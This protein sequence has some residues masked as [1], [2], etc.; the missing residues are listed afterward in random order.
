MGKNRSVELIKRMLKEQ[1]CCLGRVFAR[2]EV[3]DDVIWDVVKGFDVIY[4]KIIQ[5]AESPAGK[6]IGGSNP[7]ANKIEPHP[8]LV[9]LLDKIEK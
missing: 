5:R 9:Y 8:G 7:P 4:Q 6:E 1:V 2:N 3:P